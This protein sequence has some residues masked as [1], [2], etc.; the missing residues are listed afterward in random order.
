MKAIIASFAFGASAALIPRQRCCFSLSS[1][2][3]AQGAVTQLGDG[4]NRIVNSTGSG[5]GTS[6][7][8]ET[9]NSQYCISNGA[10]TDSKR[11]RL[12]LDAA[13]DSVPV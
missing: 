12:H 2:G 4:Q 7:S 9:Y 6:G 3:G 8:E 13:N 10:I 5:S 11:P 1:S